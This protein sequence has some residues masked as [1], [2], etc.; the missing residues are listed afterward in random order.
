MLVRGPT[1][2]IHTP[3]RVRALSVMKPGPSSLATGRAGY[4]YL[5]ARKTRVA[6]YMHG[7]SRRTRE[8][9]GCA[10]MDGNVDT[11]ELCR[12]DRVPGR[13]FQGRVARDGGDAHELAVPS[14]SE[15]RKLYIWNGSEENN[16][17]RDKR[18]YEYF[19]GV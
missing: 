4:G 9:P 5:D 2:M 1:A 12:H 10:R 13:V 15:D 14:G 6:V 3:G 11:R 17:K 8:R 18:G 16:S 7:V 19:E